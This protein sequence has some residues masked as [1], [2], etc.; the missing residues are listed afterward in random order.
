MKG[1]GF[2]YSLQRHIPN[3]LKT[4][5]QWHLLGA[6]IY[7]VDLWEICNIQTTVTM[8]PI[9]IFT[10][11]A[12]TTSAS[13]SH[14]STIISI[15]HALEG[16]G[17]YWLEVAE[18]SASY[19]GPA[20]IARTESS[21]GHGLEIRREGGPWRRS[22]WWRHSP[23]STCV[24]DSKGCSQAIPCP[25]WSQDSCTAMTWEQLEAFHPHWAPPTLHTPTDSMHWEP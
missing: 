17:F 14:G 2:Y 7:H 13:C 21:A 4:T 3:H 25:S 23:E 5:S 18:A 6:S 22:T 20:S 19:S 8:Y 12:I 9:I 10:I 16:E 15:R 24:Q 1:Q 11:T